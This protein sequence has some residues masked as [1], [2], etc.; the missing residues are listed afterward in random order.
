MLPLEEA[1]GKGSSSPLQH[2]GGKCPVALPSKTSLSESP[3]GLEQC[4]RATAFT[5]PPPLLL[6]G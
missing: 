6:W 5:Q 2:M 4:A 3:V 1:E